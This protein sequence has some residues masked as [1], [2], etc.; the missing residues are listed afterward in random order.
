MPSLLLDA[1]DV[2]LLA[3]L[4]NDARRS[5][6]ELAEAVGLSPSPCLRRMRQLERRGVIRG[7]VTLVDP[8]VVG[9]P[10][11]V[12]VNV[13]LKTHVEEA[14]EVFEDAIRE[15]PEVMECYLMTGEADYLLRV[16]SAD[17]ATYQRFLMD[18]LTRIPGVANVRS[19]FAL[20]QVQYR[21]AMPLA[22]LLASDRNPSSR[23]PQR[24][25]RA[26]RQAGT[27][28]RAGRQARRA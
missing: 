22:H 21:T 18:H 5:N 16:V 8:Q 12:F 19:S 27:R 6:V 28:G 23:S 20:K 24:T 7:Y 25:S 17:L 11:S 15:R 9:L 1:L 4:Q 3:L 2:K 10:V 14:L 13:T 26:R